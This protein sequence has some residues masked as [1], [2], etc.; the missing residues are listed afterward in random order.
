MRG[1]LEREVKFSLKVLLSYF[2]VTHGHADIFVSEQL[3]QGWK[4]DAQADHFRCVCVPK[5]MA[6]DGIGAARAL[7][8]CP[9][10]H[11]DVSIYGT[12][13]GGARQ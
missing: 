5:L 3:H 1:F 13:A 7:R 10:R 2:H 11:A 9:Y 12:M 8:R 4:A 6:A